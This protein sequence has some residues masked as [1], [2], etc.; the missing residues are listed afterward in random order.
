MFL[1]FLQKKGTPFQIGSY[2]LCIPYIHSYVEK[3]GHEDLITS[4]TGLVFLTIVH[5]SLRF[6]SF[7]KV[8]HTILLIHLVMKV[9]IMCLIGIFVFRFACGLWIDICTIQLGD[10]TLSDRLSLFEQSPM[11]TIFSYW[12]QGMWSTF[13]VF[14]LMNAYLDTLRPGLIS[15]SFFRRSSDFVYED[16]L[17]EKISMSICSYLVRFIVMFCAFA[18][19]SLVTLFLPFKMIGFLF[20]D[21]S[22]KKSQMN[23]NDQMSFNEDPE[24]Y[25]FLYSLI[26]VLTNLGI[27]FIVFEKE[28]IKKLVKNSIFLWTR[29]I[30]RMCGL[31]SILLADQNPDTAT[32]LNKPV[33]FKMKVKYKNDFQSTTYK[34]FREILYTDTVECSL[35]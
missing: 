16:I 27:Y 9:L 17:K 1:F 11:R 29:L 24:F 25:Y 26:L 6:S 7:K 35:P 12:N 15:I 33:H 8:R 20:G 23:A 10:A 34:I 2:V 18:C 30:A 31:E 4:F 19:V 13:I 3:T 28:N 5:V 22:T 21:Y 32:C 14:R